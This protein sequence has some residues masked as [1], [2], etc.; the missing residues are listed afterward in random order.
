M[1]DLLQLWTYSAV[2]VAAVTWLVNLVLGV[3]PRPPPEPWRIMIALIFGL[4]ALVFA[5]ILG[6]S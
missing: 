4:L 1:S 5:L 2:L 3:H 6:H